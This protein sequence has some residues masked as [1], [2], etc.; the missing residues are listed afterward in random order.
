MIV[1][2]IQ[3]PINRYNVD[4]DYNYREELFESFISESNGR[5]S[6]FIACTEPKILKYE[7]SFSQERCDL[8]MSSKRKSDLKSAVALK[9]VLNY[10]IH[11]IHVRDNKMNK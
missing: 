1:F 7:P 5:I 6:V 11:T 9:Q 3:R 10:G 8:D 4:N 2:D